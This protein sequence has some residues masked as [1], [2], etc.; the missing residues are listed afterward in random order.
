MG[1]YQDIMGDLH[2]LFGRVNEVHVFLDEDEPCGHYIE[3]VIEGTTV[4]LAL[5]SVQYDQRELKRHMKRQ[6]DR[7][8]KEDQMKPREGM[9][10]LRDYDQGLSDYTYLGS[11]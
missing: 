5:S 6:V 8:I 9:R 4:G 2:N 7:A 10:L 11:L 1:A 3:E